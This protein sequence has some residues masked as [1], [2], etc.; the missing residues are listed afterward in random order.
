MYES[1]IVVELVYDDAQY[2]V[3]ICLRSFVLFPSLALDFQHFHTTKL[4]R[5]NVCHKL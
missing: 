4:S 2:P 5:A 1:V 3:M